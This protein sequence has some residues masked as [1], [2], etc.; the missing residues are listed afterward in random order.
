MQSIKLVVVG[1]G[2]TGKTSLLIS[3]STNSFPDEYVPTIFDNYSP[4][5]KFEDG[6][7]TK[8]INLGLWDTAGSEDYDRLRSLSYPGTDVFLICFS[9]R[10]KISFTNVSEKWIKEV[11]KHNPSTP[12]ILVGTMSDTRDAQNLK[13][14]EDSQVTTFQQ[15]ANLAAEIGAVMYLEVSAFKGQGLQTLFDEAIRVVLHPPKEESQ[16]TPCICFGPFLSCSRP[17]FL[18]DNETETE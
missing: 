16:K 5:V 6:G 4:Q 18:A 1:D 7:E 12:V 8:D 9:I 11:Q 3:Y 2:G 13:K 10:N 17:T 15:G 14:D